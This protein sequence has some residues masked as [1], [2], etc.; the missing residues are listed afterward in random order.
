[1][2]DETAEQLTGKEMHWE[3]DEDTVIPK[4]TKKSSLDVFKVAKSTEKKVKEEESNK[5][6]SKKEV[7]KK[8]ESKK[9]ESKTEENVINI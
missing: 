7:S 3:K 9:E 5:E 8:E 2:G 4:L 1:M 6:E